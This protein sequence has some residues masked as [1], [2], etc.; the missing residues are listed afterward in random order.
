[1]ARLK[2]FQFLVL[3]IFLL[4]G[5]QAQALEKFF[6]NSAG[7]QLIAFQQNQMWFVKVIR[8]N[9]SRWPELVEEKQYQDWRQVENLV[10]QGRFVADLAAALE[11]TSSAGFELRENSVVETSEG[12]VLWKAENQWSWDW[13]VKYAEWLQNHVDVEF[14]KKYNIKTDCA[15]VQYYLRWIFSRIYKLPMASR[16]PGGSYL[17]QNSMKAEWAKL[18]THE[19]WHKDKRFLAAMV[20]L[21]RLVY[22]H[23]LYRDSYPVELNATALLPGA[24]YLTISGKSGHTMVIYRQTPATSGVRI[25]VMSSTVPREVRVLYS[26]R[27]VAGEYAVG[28]AAMLRMRWPRIANGQVSL[29]DEK[30]MPYYSTQQFE[31]QN[32]NINRILNPNPNWHIEYDD[33][34]QL[35]SELLKQRKVAVQDGY[36]VCFPNKCD[37][38]GSDWDNHSTPSRDRRIREAMIYFDDELA[39]EYSRYA[40]RSEKEIIFEYEGEGYNLKNLRYLFELNH[41]SIDPNHSLERRWP[42]GPK[43][44][45]QAISERILDSLKSRREKIQ[46]SNQLC[47]AP[48]NCAVGSENFKNLN[49]HQTTEEIL[50][51]QDHLNGYS[52]F[53]PEQKNLFDSVSKSP[54]FDGVSQ[55]SFE[56]WMHLLL[57]SSHDPRS[58]P[59][60]KEGDYE[61]SFV[62]LKLEPSERIYDSTK[63]G[64]IFVRKSDEYILYQIRNQQLMTFH[65]VGPEEKIKDYDTKTEEVLVCVS[66]GCAFYNYNT[67]QKIFDLPSEFVGDHI[68]ISRHPGAIIAREYVTENDNSYSRNIKVYDLKKKKI[69]FSLANGEKIARFSLTNDLNLYSYEIYTDHQL[70]SS[71]KYLLE[72]QKTNQGAIETAF[73]VSLD[74]VEDYVISSRYLFTKSGYQMVL[75]DL[76][77]P[78]K[79]IYLGFLK[80]VGRTGIISKIFENKYNRFYRVAFDEKSMRFHESEIT[81]LTPYKFGESLAGDHSVSYFFSSNSN[82]IL[83]IDHSEEK[84]AKLDYRILV[85]NEQA[86][87]MAGSYTTYAKLTPEGMRYQTRHATKGALTGWTSSY[88][89][90]YPLLNHPDAYAFKSYNEQWYHYIYLIS[91][92]QMSL[93]NSYFELTA[94]GL[95]HNSNEIWLLK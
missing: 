74:A 81:E 86:F 66:E 71:Q 15:D 4:T 26:H 63:S 77:D 37:L 89:D 85:Q 33:A 35:V 16:L 79:I 68:S 78:E 69:I 2:W 3:S 45:T 88:L 41:P 27:P 52:N 39:T 61:D 92:P 48:Q 20:Y 44:F 9:A 57:F 21:T 76:N 58:K 56:Q 29:V 83:E 12:E 47:R 90:L 59:E 46:K 60:H 64:L 22:T 11:I 36:K 87:K 50:S 49:L 13:E 75:F 70:T 34:V 31:L 6:R 38:A 14:F 55:R 94:T 72:L 24:F 23:T 82:H 28:K 62:R 80:S 53:Y 84:P 19:I 73:F 54:F 7:E 5:F 93:L 65:I 42:L 67:K 10:Q 17:T 8:L 43:R 40:E 25:L 30:K 91:Q 1:M 18:P 51:Y 95:L 32:P